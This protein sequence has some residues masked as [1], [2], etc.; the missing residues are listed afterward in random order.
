MKFTF[1]II[2]SIG[3][4]K[5]KDS[6]SFQGLFISSFR[7]G[8]VGGHESKAIFFQARLDEVPET[9]PV[10]LKP[11]TQL[12]KPTE[13]IFFSWKLG[14]WFITATSVLCCKWPQWPKWHLTKILSHRWRC[15]LVLQQL[16]TGTATPIDTLT[17][18][19]SYTNP[20]IADI[21]LVVHRSVKG[22][23]RFSEH[24]RK[25]LG[26]TF[27]YSFS[28]NTNSLKWIWNV[29][30]LLKTPIVFFTIIFTPT[31]HQGS[32]CKFQICHSSSISIVF[33]KLIFRCNIKG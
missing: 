14:R 17:N 20:F 24:F 9:Y 15:R 7:R 19:W 2:E 10:S 4:F 33:M 16:S 29:E 27:S 8:K 13:P 23:S 22:T 3:S 31:H 26:N 28:T 5:V 12:R 30:H 18:I 21:V 1:I 25:T 32:D 6:L 11:R